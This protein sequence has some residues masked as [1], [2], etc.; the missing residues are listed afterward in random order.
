MAPHPVPAL[1]EYPDIEVRQ[2][3][4]DVSCGPT[5][6][7]G[8][9]RYLGHAVSLDDVMASVPRLEHGGTLGVLMG[10]DALRHG[11]E[12]TIFTY[13]LEVFDPTWF[14]GEPAE[15]RPRLVEQLSYKREPRFVAAVEA[16]E[17][18]LEAGGE[19]RH[20]ELTPALLSVLVRMGTPPITGLSATY[21]Y[22]C[23]REVWEG[24]SSIFD[25]VRGSPVGHFVVLSGVDD[26]SGRFRISDPSADN[27][28]HGSG[29]YWVNAHRL[30]GAILLGA[31][32]YDGNI[33]VIRPAG[34]LR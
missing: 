19:V 13:N 2:Q 24:R 14:E 18:F 21:L 27:P 17:A 15:L 29:T 7:H 9:Y 6:L 31:T 16:Y 30:L 33:L 28:R 26:D 11:F 32:T 25:S 8:L 10:L 1:F 12:V 23:E 3:P 22:G 20:R 34:E 5:C 4:D